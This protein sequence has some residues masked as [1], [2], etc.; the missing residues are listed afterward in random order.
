VLGDEEARMA[1]E[2][3]AAGTI[4]PPV[5]ALI[6]TAKRNEEKG[7]DAVWYPDHWMAWH[8]ESIWQPD[9]TPLAQFQSNP[10]VYLDPIACI[11]AA[12]SHTERIRFGTCVTETVR[13]HPALLANEWLT[14]DHVTK[15]RAI[16]G[17][18]SGEKEN[19]EP[20]GLRYEKVV[21]RYEE[22][23]TIIR[24]LWENDEPI[25]FDGSFWTLR[26]AVNGMG[27]YQSGRFPPIWTGA[28][29]PRMCAITGRLA[30]G[31]LPS[32]KT[33]DEYAESLRIVRDAASKA[34]R[35]PDAI[36]P[37]LWQ[38]AVPASDHE[39]AH[40][41][42]DTPLIRAYMLVLGSAAFERHGY[43][44]PLGKGFEGIR[45]YIPT[46]VGRE[47]ALK[48]SAQVPEEVLH[49][50]VPHGT[51]DDLAALARVYEAAG[52]K[53]I[54]LWNVTFLGDP[55]LVRESYHL[56]DDLLA[57]LKS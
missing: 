25:D 3:G 8:P 21:S 32:L 52:C 29:G 6:K 9:I 7:Y 1:I 36:T 47:E 33:P 34:G 14:L 23:L 27:P 48:A 42:L 39:T 50:N 49:E 22:A 26:D 51:P 37:G 24:L 46:R 10:H 4:T 45:D 41:L 17:V 38:Y 54:V 35:D 28:H 57:I 13:R 18:G 44:H 43:E 2:V 31:W 55:S 12:G 5:D 53:H 15:G 16:L 19:I 40:R 11:A 56:M 20:Y 30:D